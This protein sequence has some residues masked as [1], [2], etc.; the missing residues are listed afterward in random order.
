MAQNLAECIAKKL[1][2]PMCKHYMHPPILQCRMGHPMCKDC[3]DKL[4]HCRLCHKP[5]INEERRYWSLEK[6]H[7][8]VTFP[9]KYKKF[10][11]L[12]TWLGQD[13]VTHEEHCRFDPKKSNKN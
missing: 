5:K 10:G 9:C 7:E 1:E 11:C 4:T 3:Y 13:I 12:E 2:C 8:K 6:I